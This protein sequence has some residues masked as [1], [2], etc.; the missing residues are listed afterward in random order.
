ML[1][2][3][4]LL[5]LIYLNLLVTAIGDFHGNQFVHC[6]ELSDTLTPYPLTVDKRHS[7]WFVLSPTQFAAIIVDR[8]GA[9]VFT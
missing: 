5:I 9:M 4:S 6:P 2:Q 3:L 8:A 1:F 7:L